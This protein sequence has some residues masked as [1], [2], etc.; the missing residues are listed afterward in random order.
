MKKLFA[1]LCVL[2]AILIGVVGCSVNS[3]EIVRPNEVQLDWAE[4]EI[5][6][7]IHFDMPVFVPEY[8]FREWGTHP[9]PSVFNPSSLDTDQW[10]ET[11]SK[12]GAKYAVLV[13][14][15]CSGFSLWPTEAH[16]YSVKNCPWKDGK[17][18][19]VA[20]FIASCKKYGIKPG[21]YASTTANGFLH[22]D[23]PG[24]VQEG[25]PVT[26]EEYNAIVT[27]Q[28]TELWSNYGDLFE[29][30]FDGGVLS[31]KEGGADVLSLV[32]ELQP[33]AIAFQGP[34]GHENLIRWVGNEHGTAPDPCWATADSTTN[35]DGVRVVEGL[36][37]RPDAPFW[38]PGESDFTLR[39][40]RS[41][42]GGWFWTGGQ[43]DLLFSTD[44]L[45]EK[46]E[47]SVGRNTNML[48]GMVIDDRGLVP[49]ADIQRITEFGDAI[50]QRYGNPVAGTSGNKKELLL[51]LKNP[52]MVDRLVIQEDISEGERVLAWHVEGVRPDGS[53][54]T[55]CQGTN[56]GHKRIAKFEPVELTSLKLMVD[57]SKAGP[58]IRNFAVFASDSPRIVNIINF[59]RYTEP[60]SEAITEKVLYETVLSQ[61]KDL[62][63]KNLTGTYLLQYDAL[64]DPSYQA[65]MK[66]EIDRGCEVGAWWEI[67]QPHVEAAGYTWR[68]RFP[69]DWHANVGFSVG[70]TQEERERL[71]DVYMEK[72]KDIFGFYPK[73]VGSWFIEAGTLAYLHD[74]YGIEASCSCKDQI[75]TDGYTI[76]GGYWNG[77]YYPSRENA[78]MPAQTPEGGIGI[79]IFRMLGCD[80][81]YQYEAGLGGSVQSVVTLEPVYKG[82]GGNP[83]W[84][85]WFFRMF[86][87]EPHM[88]YNYVQ[89]GQENSFTW[90]AME[91]GFV[92]QTDRLVELRDKGKVRIETL[93]QTGRWFKEK[94]KVTPP[95]SVITTEDYLGNGRQTLWFNSRYYRT[96]LLW[97]DSSLKFR[98]I[99]L[100]DENLRSEYLD[101][102]DTLSI[103]HYETLPI[104]DGCL[105]SNS[106][107][108]AGLRFVTPGFDG[109]NPVFSSDNEK[110]QVVTWPSKDGK[111]RFIISFTEKSIEIR[112]ENMTSK[113][114]LDLFTAP[115]VKLPFTD[116]T[117]K[118][119]RASYRGFEYGVALAQ[120]SVEDLREQ[121]GEISLRLRPK[122][123][124]IVLLL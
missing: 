67:T 99:H 30:W 42:Q 8:N 46:Y 29:I 27:K 84:V 65:L 88:G 120:G 24:L 51:K 122:G 45:M 92:C 86:T 82:G 73:S 31:P 101:H 77:G 41:F 25:S 44:E 15:H 43:D 14:K 17:G 32:K 28:L 62:R 79:P 109:G 81:I 63:S 55:I 54:I 95:S 66:E 89:V 117:D 111:G 114:S 9:D 33:K 87:R 16:E 36:T 13:A 64:I 123:D 94:Y 3:S 53:T 118:A 102:P 93:G 90:D 47:T 52:T 4:A 78:Y 74:K 37:G 96:N 20:D 106:D 69:W 113:W 10:M 50:R 121:D 85:D 38:C 100:F 116:I 83:E 57:D 12:L 110:I 61:A 104:L 2:T 70:Y 91:K 22:V 103:L 56:I 75:G 18:D 119:I 71:V 98:D 60:R 35:S 40:N 7:L 39:Y 80:P 6:V 5:G 19:I 34:Y 21:I 72:F 124:R 68:G 112:S 23:N 105:W 58:R 59:I 108:L 115:G 97:E 11:A 76:W 1:C 107:N 26:Q 48:L 49:D